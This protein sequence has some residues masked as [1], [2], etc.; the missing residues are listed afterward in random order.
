MND[1]TENMAGADQAMPFNEA[2]ASS[3]LHQVEE[4][5]RSHPIA[6]ALTTLGI[7]CAVG[8]AAREL[9]HPPQ[10]TTKERAINLLEDI[11][12]RLGDLLEPAT[13]RV[14]ELADD[15]VSAIKSGLHSI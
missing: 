13:D 8:V 9:L 11:Q 7:G 4:L 15:G 14:S 5:I 10:T 2:S 6:T 3:V 1:P 12:A